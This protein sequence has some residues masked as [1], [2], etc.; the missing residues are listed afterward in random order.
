LGSAFPHLIGY[1][2]I[3]GGDSLSGMVARANRMCDYSLHAIASR[4]AR[5]G[6]TLI[7]TG[8]RGTSTLGFASPAEEGVAVC[9]LP[10]TELAFEKNVRRR[11]G[12]FR[13]HTLKFNVAKFCK[14]SPDAPGQHHDA[15]T[16]PDGSTVLV[17]SLVQRQRVRVLQLP[18]TVKGFERRDGEALPEIINN[19]NV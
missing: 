14:I 13:S 12:W 17:N 4:P 18:A 9:L 16:F 15:L 6:E 11:A 3:P 1:P 5:A 19:E 2:P 8:F 7:S 10:G